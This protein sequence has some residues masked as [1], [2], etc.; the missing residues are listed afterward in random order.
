MDKGLTKEKQDRLL[1]NA[2]RA[3][4]VQK[5]MKIAKNRTQKINK[6]TFQ[7][8]SALKKGFRQKEF[9][10]S[11]IHSKIFSTHILRKLYITKRIKKNEAARN[12]AKYHCTKGLHTYRNYARF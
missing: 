7:S 3:S 9:C 2:F 4:K 1:F 12:V 11:R 10:S 8:P 5:L 6:S